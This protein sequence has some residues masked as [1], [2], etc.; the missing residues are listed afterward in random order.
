MQKIR[1]LIW[2]L[3]RPYLYAQLFYQAKQNLF[4]HKK[5]ATR[6]VSTEWC[7]NN[8]IDT[9]EALFLLTGKK[10]LEKIEELAKKDFERAHR[11]QESLSLK[12]GG[13]GDHNLLF[14][15]VKHFGVQSIVETGVAYGWSSLSILTA[16]E[17]KDHALL[18]STDMPYAKMGNEEFVGCV[19]PDRLKKNWILIRRP[20]RQALKKVFKKLSTIDMCH[21]DSDKSYRGRMWA[22]PLLWSKL[23]SGGVFISDDINDNLAFKD[24]A[25]ALQLKPI[26]VSWK[27]QFVGIIVKP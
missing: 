10:N 4:P 27:D 12:M 22:Y 24:F 25:D 8:S 2:F 1:T 11:I 15:I 26:I 23:K 18:M 6:K 17:N 5:E 14:H 13:G 16:L 20:D 21:Y 7:N 3:K 9:W 19:I